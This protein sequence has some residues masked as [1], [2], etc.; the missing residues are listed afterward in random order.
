MIVLGLGFTDHEASVA[1]VIDGIV[2]CAISRERLSRIKRDGIV[3][4]SRTLNLS[5]AISY[6]LA[7]S[8][9]SIHEVDLVVWN[10]INHISSANLLEQLAGEGGCD[11][12]LCPAMVLPHHFAH[13][14]CS[15]YLSG[16]KSAAILVADGSGGPLS[17]LYRYCNGP[18]PTALRFS[19]APVE[20]LAPDGS[21]SAREL[22]SFY[23]VVEGKWRVLRKVVG[24]GQGIGAQYASASELLFGDFLDAGKTMGL[25]PYGIPYGIPTF[26]KKTNTSQKKAQTFT[27]NISSSRE[28][29]ERRIR[30]F[31]STTAPINYVTPLFADYAATIQ[32]ET[33]S[34]LAEYAAW[35]KRE[36]G[37]QNLCLSG[38]V[39]LNCVANSRISDT[40][41][42]ASVFVPPAPGDDGIAIGCA[43]YGAAVNGDVPKPGS[44]P[45]LGKQYFHEPS[46]FEDIGLTRDSEQASICEIT[47]R[48]LAKGSVV[49]WFQGRSEFGPRALGNRSFLADPRRPDMKDRINRIIK[50]RESFRPFAPVV[51]DNAVD[52][53]FMDRYPS[54]FM[55]FVARVRDDKR[56]VVPAIT[57]VD[58]TAR[59]QV[60]RQADNPLL[61]SLI[62][63]FRK[64]T[65][66]P[67]LLNTS[68]NRAG[69]PLVETPN[70]AAQC[71]IES[72]ADFLVIDGVS[73]R[74]QRS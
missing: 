52:E 16:F 42:F 14:C 39:A 68:L 13:A 58:G 57:H 31:L 12:G 54:H 10:H 47:A 22:E 34:A 73:Y 23:L 61:Y 18:E 30:K 35:L 5:E 27:A 4:G 3:W 26:L 65:S 64:L 69:E 43:L 63:E 36:T 15:Y 25:A 48:E 20:N 19:S 50:N 32:S 40:A 53:F 45:F 66:L 11:F 71:F 21:P 37:L 67:L 17:G 56:S 70:Q 74:P 41:G 72:S 28:A 29:V 33:E 1:M 6:C 55:S 60:L 62:V 51:L 2:R 9:V 38:G 8:G 59:Y 7:A 49:A 24:I 46:E 44:F